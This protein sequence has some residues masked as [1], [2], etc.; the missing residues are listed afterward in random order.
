[1]AAHVTQF[2]A[3]P[4][5]IHVE[6]D[7]R[8]GLIIGMANKTVH[9]S[10]WCANVGLKFY[11]GRYSPN[12]GIGIFEEILCLNDSLSV[13]SFVLKEDSVQYSAFSIAVLLEG[14]AVVSLKILEPAGCRL[15]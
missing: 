5:D 8:A 10:V 14:K 6:K 13:T 3:N 12:F 15:S 7:G 2:F 11:Q 9:L 4:R 1:V